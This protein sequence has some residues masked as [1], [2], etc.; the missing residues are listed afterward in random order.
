MDIGEYISVRRIVTIIN[1]LHKP[2]KDLKI[3]CNNFMILYNKLNYYYVPKQME[4]FSVGVQRLVLITA[5]EDLDDENLS[6]QD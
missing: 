5:I 3:S 2:C 6:P 4:T 1:H